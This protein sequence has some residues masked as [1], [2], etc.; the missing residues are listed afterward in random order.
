M[1]WSRTEI[2]AGYRRNGSQATPRAPLGSLPTVDVETLK[3]SARGL[4]FTASEV[5]ILLREW[6]ASALR[7]AFLEALTEQLRRER[8][9]VEDAPA[10]ASPSHLSVLVPLMANDGRSFDATYLA[11]AVAPIF[12]VSSGATFRDADG[13]DAAD[14]RVCFDRH[15]EIGV[16]TSNGR[17]LLSL[18][19]AVCWFL[20]Q[21]TLWVTDLSTGDVYLVSPDAVTSLSLP[22][23]P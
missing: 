8:F 12:T 17:R 2:D 13:L 14:G 19:R 11:K 7:A 20:A 9:E 10:G 21:R 5:R 4:G 22:R 18:L 1:D 6:Q 15:V 3:S 16:W 23:L